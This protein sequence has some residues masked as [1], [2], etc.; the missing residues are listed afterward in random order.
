MIAALLDRLWAGLAPDPG[1]V[2]F[3]HLARRPSGN[4][5]LAAPPEAGL[6]AG[7]DLAPSILPVPAERL[8]A[9]LDQVAASE[10]AT[11]LPGDAN[12]PRYRVRSRILRFPDMVDARLEARG[13]GRST[14]LLYSRSLVG[15]KDF[16]VNRARLRRW[17]AAIERGAA[18][19]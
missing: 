14:L 2:S 6:G 13:E 19:G 3:A 18:E 11:R 16:G 4:D 5:A 7:A 15:R 17:L 10:G 8:R 1:P 9:I 12:Q